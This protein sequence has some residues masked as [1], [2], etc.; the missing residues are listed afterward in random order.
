M[1]D[2]MRRFTSEVRHLSPGNQVQVLYAEQWPQI[3]LPR[4]GLSKYGLPDRDGFA[5]SRIRGA[6]HPVPGEILELA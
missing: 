2:E 1:S 5:M 4:S 6:S 3:N